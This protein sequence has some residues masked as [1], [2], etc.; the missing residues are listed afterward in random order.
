MQK[1]LKSQRFRKYKDHL[2]LSERRCTRQGTSEMPGL[3]DGGTRTVSPGG[4]AASL[5]LAGVKSGGEPPRGQRQEAEKPADP[6]ERGEKGA[7]SG[8]TVC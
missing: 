7:S 5:R 4:S 1:T 6:L 8:G 3:P 2:H